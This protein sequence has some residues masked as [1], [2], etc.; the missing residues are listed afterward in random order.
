MKVQTTDDARNV[1]KELG[2]NLEEIC[3][4]YKL[5]LNDAF[6][7]ELNHA[8]SNDD[9]WKVYDGTPDASL[10]KEN[11]LIALE[12][13]YKRNLENATDDY[14]RYRAYQDIYTVMPEGS[15]LKVEAFNYIEGHHRKK[16]QNAK[17]NDERWTIYCNIEKTSILKVTT[18]HLILKNAIGNDERWKVHE[19]ACKHEK[20]DLKDEALNAIKS[21]CKKRLE[22]AENNS[23]RWTVYTEIPEKDNHWKIKIL[24]E[25]LKYSEYNNERWKVY[26]EARDLKE[27]DLVLHALKLI[28]KNA[29]ENGER[30]SVYMYAPRNHQFRLKAIK[31]YIENYVE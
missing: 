15:Y 12:R 14:K 26:Y 11:A 29:T 25:I 10:A 4:A 24:H 9:L 13:R 6:Q 28:L 1:S 23:E 19:E 8:E 17:D 31:A 20:R 18:L 22:E 16:L 30:K 21:N 5:D 3:S 7:K 27:S 2:I